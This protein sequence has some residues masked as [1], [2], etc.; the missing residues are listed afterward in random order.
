MRIVTESAEKVEH[1]RTHDAYQRTVAAFGAAVLEGRE[2]NPSG[3]DGLR[4][5]QLTE[6]IA[7][8]VRESRVIELS[9]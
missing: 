3:L 4:S 5:V 8:S 2:P 6:A 7:R 9:Y 1:Y